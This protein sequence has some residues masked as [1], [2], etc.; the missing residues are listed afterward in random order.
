MT[1]Q[2]I[3]RWVADWRDRRRAE[4]LAA[5]E[6]TMRAGKENEDG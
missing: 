6:G 1:D 3:D 4:R 5:L 2:D